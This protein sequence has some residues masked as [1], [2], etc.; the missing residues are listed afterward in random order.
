[1]EKNIENTQ[2]EAFARYLKEEE[3]SKNTIEK[4]IRDVKSFVRYVNGMEISK[5]TV[6][7]YK[8]K[9]ISD[10]YAVRSVNSM[11]ASLNSLFSF[12]NWT[13]CKVKFIKFQQEVYNPKERELTKQEY[14]RLI[15]AAK[16]R[17]NKRLS[18]IIQTICGTGIRVSELKYIT[19]EAV[20]KGEAIV[21]LKGKT[22]YVCIVNKLRKKL[23]A[24]ANEQNISKGTIFITRSGKTISRSNI[25][26]DMKKLCIQARENPKKVFPHNLRRL[27]ALTFYNME[28]DIAK[29]A[30]ILGHNNINTTRIYVR[31]TFDEHCLRMEKLQLVI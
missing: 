14:V 9:L 3:K 25:W 20:K 16:K 26:R 22:R 17:G 24:Y 6:I 8:N 27:F 15:D 29:L 12:L 10:N 4:Y 13:D 18:L 30:D 11:I 31:T 5:E 21:S 1:M 19:V 7:D 23:L 2:I 28:K